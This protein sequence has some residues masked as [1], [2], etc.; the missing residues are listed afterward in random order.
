MEEEEKERKRRVEESLRK[1]EEEVQRA[2]AGHLR[3]SG[4]MSD[5]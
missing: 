2:L 5:L 1:R 4:L 3:V